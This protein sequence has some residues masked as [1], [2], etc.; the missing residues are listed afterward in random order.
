MTAAQPAVLRE[1]R[2]PVTWLTLNRPD[3]MN[4]L[5]P[6]LLNEFDSH[7]R[8]VGDD[9]SVRV[10]VITANG[11]AFCAGADLKAVLGTRGDLD[12]ARLLDFEQRAQATFARLADLPKPT[13][14][15]L[16]GVT[17]AGGLELALHCDLV[18]ASSRARI[19]DG[20]TNYGLLPGAG[21]AARLPRVIGPTRAKYLAFTGELISAEQALTMGLVV[22][23]L[24]P[25][26][27]RSRIESLSSAIAVRSPSAL[28]LFKQTIDDGL[29]QPLQSALR[30][31]LLAT[32]AHLHTGDVEEG[33]RAFTEK[34]A[35]RFTTSEENDD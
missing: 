33:L 9:P 17:M 31:E 10:V 29:N 22:E 27:F 15:A 13:I 12:P 4:A 5:D 18:V 16:N 7:V 24:P 3:A 6:Q 35:P 34:R 14:A 2:G 11:R 32:A 26:K 21:G 19:G 30:L 25:E 28:R 8:A 23:V 20:H 1:D